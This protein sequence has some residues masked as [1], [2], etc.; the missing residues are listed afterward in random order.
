VGPFS[1]ERLDEVALARAPLVQVLAQI[2]FANDPDVAEPTR[3]RQLKHRLRD[4]YPV[5]RQEPSVEFRLDIG[6]GSPQRIDSTLWRLHDA[7]A[8]WHITFTE[9]FLALT[10]Y[11]YVSRGD[12]CERLRHV[13]TEFLETNDIALLDR[14]G[15]RYTDRIDDPEVLGS[16]DRYVRSEFLAGASV[17]LDQGVVLDRSLWEMQFRRTD[18]VVVSTRSI[19][20]PPDVTH[21]PGIKPSSGRSWV[22]DIDVYSESM[23]RFEPS[24]IAA[25]AEEYAQQAYKVFRWSVTDDFLKHYG[26]EI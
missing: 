13:L 6:G 7:D 17:P 5:L 19:F 25:T 15:V 24:S 9:G 14:L 11:E 10:T 23:T 4:D 3:A 20:L 21:D 12:F 18:E 8:K 2:R 26:G 1:P 16:L 22:L